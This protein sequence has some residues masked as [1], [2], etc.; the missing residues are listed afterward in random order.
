MVKTCLFS[1]GK[2][3]FL[4]QGGKIVVHNY[5]GVRKERIQSDMSGKYLRAGSVSDRATGSMDDNPKVG[6]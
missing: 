4:E 2:Y 5:H 3:Q 6:T 1:A